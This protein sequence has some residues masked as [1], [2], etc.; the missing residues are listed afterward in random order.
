[1][2]RIRRHLQVADRQDPERADRVIHLVMGKNRLGS[3]THP[4]NLLPDQ[5]DGL[6]WRSIDNPVNALW[7]ADNCRDVIWTATSQVDSAP[8]RFD[9][10]WN[11]LISDI[12]ARGGGLLHTGLARYKNSGL[13]LLAPPG[14]GKS[15]T[16]GT[17]PCD[18]QVLSDDAALVWPAD[19]GVW[20][21][22]PLPAWG[23]IIDPN[24]DW[25]VAKPRLDQTCRLKSLLI[26]HK[27][28]HLS[29]SP[30]SSS[31]AMPHVYRAYCE[32]PV[33]IVASALHPEPWFRAAAKLCRSVACWEIDLPLHGD[34]WPLLED[35]AA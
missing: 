21:A 4:R 33:T 15:T 22:S 34:I 13:L 1:M 16:L 10:P 5:F 17:A 25:P 35:N 2:G 11:L 18:W 19:S 28:P 27:S 31:S 6:D 20:L 29:L 9:L 12:T 32:Y 26:L 30:I 24:R 14:G 23:A 7:L 8:P 3:F